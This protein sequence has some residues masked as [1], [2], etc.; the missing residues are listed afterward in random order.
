[1]TRGIFYTSLPLKCANCHN[2]IKRV[3]DCKIIHL[4]KKFIICKNCPCNE[5]RTIALMRMWGVEGFTI[6]GIEV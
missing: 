1:M 2:L 6:G 4:P 5:E 3:R